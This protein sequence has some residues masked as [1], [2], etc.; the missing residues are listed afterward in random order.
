MIVDNSL[1]NVEGDIINKT[2]ATKE[3]V[4]KVLSANSDSENGRSEFFWLR[5][6]NGELALATFPRGNT[7]IEVSDTW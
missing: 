6:P 2:L 5:F 3:E 1:V 7:Y 4:V